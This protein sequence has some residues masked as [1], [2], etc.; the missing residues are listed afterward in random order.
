MANMK[1]K[2]K[3]ALARDLLLQQQEV[4]NDRPGMWV[5][6]QAQQGRG[7]SSGGGG[8]LNFH[9]GKQ[10][11]QPQPP[12]SQARQHK[13]RV[14]EVEPPSTDLVLSSSYTAGEIQSYDSVSLERLIIEERTKRS[15][16]QAE[17]ERV[18][19]LAMRNQN[20][21]RDRSAF[22][23]KLRLRD[24]VEIRDLRERLQQVE[25]ELTEQRA[26]GLASP[27]RAARNQSISSVGGG[28]HR[29]NSNQRSSPSNIRGSPR[30]QALGSDG[31]ES[32]T[33]SILTE[34]RSRDQRDRLVLEKQEQK[35]LELW[36][37]NM[38]LQRR[39][40]EQR[41][42]MSEFALRSADRITA[43]ESRLN[44]RDSSI[45]R[46]EQKESDTSQQLAMRE[47]HS[48]ANIA[49]L[50]SSMER[51]QNKVAQEQQMRTK[52][53][54][55]HRASNA[56]LRKLIFSSEKNVAS[57]IQSNVDQLWQRDAADRS[58]SKQVSEFVEQRY[59]H[60]RDSVYQWAER[61]EATLASER[62]DRLRF[63]KELRT[64]TELRVAAIEASAA[65]A[66]TS[67][68]MHSSDIEKK[69]EKVL[70]KLIK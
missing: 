7:G 5:D 42:Q 28:G 68:E 20:M 22:L 16:M 10:Y 47:V 46:L 2:N 8:N 61:L 9:T 64:M 4:R 39:V 43:I 29:Q 12:A 51:L 36:E 70:N 52:M 21:V 50:I 57:A 63:E 30:G 35:R 41:Q 48:E 69:T 23:E 56:E 66:K 44:E 3:R 15:L 18:S 11:Q 6:Q 17:L 53:E 67:T 26:A 14:P 45:I 65:Q 37:Q 38:A 54:E 34:L 24:A 49:S 32:S 59:L 19:A 55:A 40:E 13:Q 62:N 60:E 27:S 25:Q 33:S 58:R 31:L 1:K